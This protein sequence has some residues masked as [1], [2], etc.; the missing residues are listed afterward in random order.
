MS[1]YVLT[2]ITAPSYDTFDVTTGSM[3]HSAGMDPVVCV[4]VDWKTAGSITQT[5]YYIAT[6]DLGNQQVTLC[7]HSANAL[8]NLGA[9][10][11]KAQ[12]VAFGERYYVFAAGLSAFEVDP[13]T[14]SVILLKDAPSF[15]PPQD[16]RAT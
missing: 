13:S 2:N 14:S 4:K 7:T 15:L 3:C 12:V 16:D 8:G 5:N 9:A 10:T 11:L 1:S 6:V